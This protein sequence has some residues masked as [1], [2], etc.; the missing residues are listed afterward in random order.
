MSD[1]TREAIERMRWEAIWNGIVL[2]VAAVL[3]LP[4]GRGPLLWELTRAFMVLWGVVL[5]AAMLMQRLQSALRV[6]DDPPSDAFLLSNLAVGVVLLLIWGG[7]TVLLI[8]DSAT[9]APWWIAAILHV[10]GFLASHGAFS[11]VSG[12]YPGSFYRTF[13]LPVALGSFILFAAWPPAARAL[14]GWLT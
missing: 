4:L 13:N 2:V 3:L 10:V 11:A 6:V 5:M 12:V 9:G 7:Y 1:E 14:F 8:R